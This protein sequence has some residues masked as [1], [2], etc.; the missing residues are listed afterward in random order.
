MN[1]TRALQSIAKRHGC[2]ILPGTFHKSLV[3]SDMLEDMDK[4][5]DFNLASDV[6]H[7]AYQATHFDTIKVGSSTMVT[8]Y[9]APEFGE[10]TIT[11][12]MSVWTGL[13]DTQENCHAVC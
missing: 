5:T 9:S 1:I 12:K 3:P 4:A 10:T 6:L 13:V 7:E 11:P 2:K 8:L